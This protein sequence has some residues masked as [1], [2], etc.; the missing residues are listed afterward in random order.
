MYAFGRP[1]LSTRGQWMAA[2]L[3]AGPGAS[4][5]HRSAS[6]LRGVWPEGARIEV[7]APSAHRIDGALVRRR[8]LPDD[9]MTTIDRIRVTTTP[10]TLLDLAAVLA[11]LKLEAAVNEAEF[12]RLTDPLSL[13]ELLRRHPNAKGSGALR[14]ILAARRVGS[15][16][17]R[18][19]FERLLLALVDGAELRRPEM[20]AMLT[21]GEVTYEVDALWR[22]ERVVV[23]LDGWQSHGRRARFE[24]DRARDRRLQVA[25][26]RV[27]R[28]TWRQL[29]DE[30]RAIAADLAAVLALPARA[31]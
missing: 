24:S 11:P 12:L 22:H 8:V 3:A 20:N 28:V 5:S 7:I 26:W 17:T 1:T 25:G 15:T 18:N 14:A 10:R 31:A 9:E 27:L 16:R 23:E 6:A 29:E 19:D 4:L 2:V 30:P 21:V 13:D